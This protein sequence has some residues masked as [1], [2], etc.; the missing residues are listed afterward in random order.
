MLWNSIGTD[1]VMLDCVSVN[2]DVSP[3]RNYVSVNDKWTAVCV[4]C[5]L[6]SP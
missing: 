4:I 5:S 2:T 3:R 6:L 1:L